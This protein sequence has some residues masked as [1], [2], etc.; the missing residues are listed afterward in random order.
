MFSFFYCGLGQQGVA[1][2]DSSSHSTESDYILQRYARRREVYARPDWTRDPIGRL[3]LVL[4][5]GH[6]GEHLRNWVIP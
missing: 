6:T 5:E 3:V 4:Y 1:V 2:S